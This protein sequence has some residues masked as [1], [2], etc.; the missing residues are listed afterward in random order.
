MGPTATGKTALSLALAAEFP[1][2]IISVD[3]V[4]IYRGMD[5]GS[6]KPDLAQRQQVPHHL[7]DIL[8]PTEIW[9]AAA[10]CERAGQL[11]DQIRQRG[12]LPI[13]VG[14]SMLYF[15]LLLQGLTALPKASSELR[16][17]LQQQAAERGWGSVHRQLSRLDPIAA[18]KILPQQQRRL[19]RALEVCLLTGRPFSELIATEPRSG[20]MH[21][22]DCPVCI[23][24]M[25]GNR[26]LHRQK[27]AGRL[28]EM[29]NEGLIDEVHRL[30]Q[31]G[32]YNPELPSAKSIVYRQVYDHL[33]GK[34]DYGQMVVQCISANNR[35][36]RHQ[37]TWLRKWQTPLT[38]ITDCG[39][40]TGNKEVI[41]RLLQEFI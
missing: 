29:L 38:T 20:L 36:V 6:A 37:L 40:I 13:L 15:K 4:M 5:I 9:S 27:I 14:G 35:L 19:I 23:A 34:T 11:I 32:G 2:E 30:R 1:A 41:I 10:F 28:T 8:Q 25:P 16:L 22:Q 7:I 18:D 33:A 26:D 17:Q 24:L 3:S 21:S 31:N 12:R 39:N